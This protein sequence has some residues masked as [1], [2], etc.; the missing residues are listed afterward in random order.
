MKKLVVV[1]A[2]IL[3]C[4]SAGAK[5]SSHTKSSVKKHAKKKMAKSKLS[6]KA[7]KAKAEARKK[8]RE[9]E[10]DDDFEGEEDTD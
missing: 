8:A 7:R 2:S 3:I 6:S 9:A 10:L 1:A 5:E 4:L